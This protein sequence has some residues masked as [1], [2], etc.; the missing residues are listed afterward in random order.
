M[1]VLGIDNPKEG[2]VARKMPQLDQPRD[3]EHAGSPENLT[4]V[5]GI[6]AKVVELAV[7]LSEDDAFVVDES[8]L[9]R[10]STDPPRPHVVLLALAVNW[11]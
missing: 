10:E 4:S 11:T 6:S 8:W 2:H 3:Q 7:I 5:L 9:K 1:P